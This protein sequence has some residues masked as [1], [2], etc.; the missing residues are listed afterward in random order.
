VGGARCRWE[1]LHHIRHQPH[2][3]T[4]PVSIK[5]LYQRLNV[6]LLDDASVDD[7]IE[8]SASK[9]NGHSPSAMVATSS[10][11]APMAKTLCPLNRLRNVKRALAELAAAVSNSATSSSFEKE[12]WIYCSQLFQCKKTSRRS[13]IKCDWP[14]VLLFSTKKPT[15]S[16]KST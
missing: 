10:T 16:S 15:K 14:F 6:L 12:T 5:H 1:R 8:S 9:L 11:W 4:M 7:C 2:L 13:S 3:L